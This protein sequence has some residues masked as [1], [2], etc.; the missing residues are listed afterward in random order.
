VVDHQDAVEVLERAWEDIPRAQNHLSARLKQKIEALMAAGAGAKGFKYLL[1]TAALAKS[2]DPTIHPRAIQAGSS[3]QGAYDARSLCHKVVV[4]FEKTKGNLF[5]LSNEPFVN[6]AL[7]HPEHDKANPQLRN[8]KMAALLHDVLELMRIAPEDEVYA[9]LVHILRL[10]KS[11]ADATSV[12]AVAG[13]DDLTVSLRFIHEFLQKANGGARLVAIW[14]AITRLTNDDAEVKA[15]NPNQSDEY[16]GTIGDVEV[17][18]EGTLASATECKHRPINLD[19]VE[20]GLRKNTAGAEYIFV[21]AA[22]FHVAQ[23]NA[24]RDRIAQAA[25][26]G[27]VSLIEAEHEFPILLKLVGP[28]RRRRLGSVVA[29]ILRD[30]REFGAAEEASMLWNGLLKK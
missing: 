17:F 18:F 29:E 14:A 6:K 3:L 16:S 13:A 2:V 7:R 20:H 21:I 26:V 10:G 28:H 9:A 30:M 12:T 22:G 19:D 4:R 11:R 27:D 1:V 25:K 23:E 5:G 15:Y 8:R 24:I